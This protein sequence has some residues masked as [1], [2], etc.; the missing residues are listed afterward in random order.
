M[1]IGA[2]FFR[3]LFTNLLV[4]GTGLGPV[5]LVHHAPGDRRTLLFQTGNDKGVA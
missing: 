1:A 2:L 3:A 5:V 4:Y